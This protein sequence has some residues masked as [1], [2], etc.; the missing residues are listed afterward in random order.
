ME[1]PVPGRL[2]DPVV[3][4]PVEILTGAV[5]AGLGHVEPDRPSAGRAPL[6][7]ERLGLCERE[8]RDGPFRGRLDVKEVQ[9][10]VP[11]RREEGRDL[12]VDADVA[13]VEVVR[14]DDDARLR[15]FATWYAYFESTAVPSVALAMRK[16][17]PVRLGVVGC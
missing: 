13:P 12:R 6:R 10:G 2:R 9:V 1:V 5:E 16:S 15:P 3:G 4:D 7:E 17:C 14:P 8:F 11:R